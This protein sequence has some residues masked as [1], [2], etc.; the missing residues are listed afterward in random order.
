MGGYSAKRAIRGVPM[1]VAY[2][3][4][5]WKTARNMSE[6]AVQI[7]DTS[8]FGR[9]RTGPVRQRFHAAMNEIYKAGWAGR[10]MFGRLRRL[11]RLCSWRTREIVDV[12]RFGLRWR[13]YRRGNVADSRL[14]LRPDVFEP[15]EIASIVDLAEPGFTFVDIGANCGFYSLRVARAA[16]GAGRVIGIEPHPGMRRRLAFN[17]SLN[18]RFPVR[19]LDCA[20]GDRAGAGRLLE[21]AGNLGETRVSDRGSIAIEIRTLSDIAA[22]ENLERIDAIK[23]DV[24][25]FEDRVLD[26]FLRDAPDALLPRLIV[27]EHSWSG[28]WETDW[29]ARAGAR[30]YREQARTRWG[31][32]I[33]VRPSARALA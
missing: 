13:L 29:L 12:E 19:I 22:A 27:A 6:M 7:D 8:P 10:R 28:S 4:R 26:P 17:A 21:G 3:P 1:P 25:G 23:V 20:V 16:G 30:G 33:L 14:L 31:N 18:P 24:E 5:I 11:E 9:Y 2:R 15:E 32:V